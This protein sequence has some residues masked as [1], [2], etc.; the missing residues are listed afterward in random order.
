MALHVQEASVLAVALLHIP[1]VL[2]QAAIPCPV[3]IMRATV[4]Q[5]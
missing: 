4:A 3:V 2:T 1:A 5:C